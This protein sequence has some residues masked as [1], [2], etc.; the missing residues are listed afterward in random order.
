MAL[1][2]T[3]MVVFYKANLTAVG[4]TFNHAPSEAILSAMF[5]AIIDD[6]TA[7][8]VVTT[9]SGAPNAEHVGII[10]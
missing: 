8:A 6:I 10:E 3:Q 9:T 7:N 4:I 2:A 1:S 5:Q